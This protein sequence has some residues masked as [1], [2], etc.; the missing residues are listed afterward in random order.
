MAAISLLSPTTGRSH[1]YMNSGNVELAQ[2]ITH[3]L[4]GI[5]NIHALVIVLARHDPSGSLNYPSALYSCNYNRSTTIVAYHGGSW[6]NEDGG[7]DHVLYTSGADV[8]F[9]NRSATTTLFAFHCIV[10]VGV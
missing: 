8:I 2:N 9:K 4:T 7:S 3:T 1:L 5:A 10:C 6:D